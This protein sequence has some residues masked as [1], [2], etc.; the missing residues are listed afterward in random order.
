MLGE[1]IG[2]ETGKVTGQRV[3]ASEDGHPPE[4]E[5]SIQ[6]NGKILGI[7]FSGNGTYVAALRPTGHLRGEGQG[8]WMTKDGEVVTWRG[9]GVGRPTGR[10]MAVSWRGA[11][12]FQ[13]TSSKLAKLNGLCGIFEHESDDN[14]NFKSAVW[15]W[16]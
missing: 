15:D 2:E 7:D 10:G 9:T 6:S 11:I 1:K 3:L 13:T 12:Y 14:G 5:V 8:I 4:M 16:K